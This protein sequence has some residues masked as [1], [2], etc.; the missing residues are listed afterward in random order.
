MARWSAESSVYELVTTRFR[1]RL[2]VLAV[3][4]RD[5]HANRFSTDSRDSDRDRVV[6]NTIQRSNP[7]KFLSACFRR[8]ERDLGVAGACR[9]RRRERH[10]GGC[11]RAS[12]MQES[13]ILQGFLAFAKSRRRNPASCEIVRR[14]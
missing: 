5:A 2:L 13:R 1:P 10:H 3:A 8:I 4:W 7:K 11:S 14:A 12:H 6:D 9:V